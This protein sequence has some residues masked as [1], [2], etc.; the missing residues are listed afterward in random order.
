MGADYLLTAGAVSVT[1]LISQMATADKLQIRHFNWFRGHSRP[2]T[3]RRGQ[4]CSVHAGRVGRQ[5]YRSGPGQENG[6]ARGLSRFE[7]PVRFGSL[8]EWIDVVYRRFHN[9]L[10]EDL[11]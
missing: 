1:I 8:S 10:A 9:A 3:Q 2:Q 5:G 4:F 7:G 11:E 6:G